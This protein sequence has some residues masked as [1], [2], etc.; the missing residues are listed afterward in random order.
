MRALLIGLIILLLVPCRVLAQPPAAPAA[1]A[2]TPAQARTALDVLND[3]RKRAEV[4]ATL[5]AIAKALPAPAEPATP[6]SPAPSPAK[7]AATTAKPVGLP[8]APNSLGAQVLVG[9]EDFLNRVSADASNGLRAMQSLPLL[10]GWIV[11]MA[12]DPWARGLLVGV[13]W[14]VAVALLCGLAV[15]FA[16]RRLIRRPVVA[17]EALA[18]S[19]RPPRT[20]HDAAT[21][22]PPEE[23]PEEPEDAAA[24]EPDDAGGEAPREPASAAAHAVERAEA[25]DIEPPLRRR[26]RPPASVFL[27]RVPLV[28]ARLVL[29]LIPVFGFAV[30]GHLV[31]ASD[32]GGQTSNRLVM[33]AVVDAYAVCAAIL[34]IA[35]MLLSPGTSRLRLFH[36]PDT[37]AAYLMRWTHRL[38]VIAVFG[39]AIAEVG[40]LLGLSDVAHDGL[41]KATGF[42]LHACLAAIVLQKRRAVRRWLRAPPGATGTIAWL[43]DAFASVWHWIALFFI[44]SIW[45]VWAVEIPHGF[46]RLLHF[47][48]VTAL[49]LIGAR[50]LLIVLTGSLDRLMNVPP[51]TAAR[52][53]G[54]EVRLRLY[55]PVLS[56]LLR[57]VVYVLCVL[58]ILQLYGFGAFTWFGESELGHR[59]VSAL[60]TFIVTLLL[61]LAAWEAANAAIQQHLAKL[62]KD[63][64]VARSARLRTLLPLMR[65]ALMI[66]ILVVAGMMVL[67]EVGINIAPLLAG[68]GIVGVAIGFGSQKL[69][70]DLITGIF[71]LLENA[72]QV[73]D[74]VTV[75]GLSGS[76][77]NLSVRTIRLRAGD[78]SV[79]IIPFSSVTTV[80][81]VNR[82]LGNASVN[83]TVEFDEDTDRVA[84]TL[85][86]IVAGMRAE[87]DFASKMLSDLQLWGVDK[88]DGAEAT[89]VGQVV[90]TDSGRWSVQREFNRRMKKRFQELGIRLYNP[91]RTVAVTLPPIR[92]SAEHQAGGRQAEPPPGTAEDEQA[93]EQSR[94]A[95]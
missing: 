46:P 92:P 84:A 30:A 57:A 12:T 82:G 91:M 73:G 20:K 38:V 88:V 83:V 35:R 36:L 45:L 61:A 28:L 64:Q 33:L 70:Q 17:L 14:R 24:D 77:E 9:A 62:A 68:A 90:C 51:E 56:A 78:G 50:L 93:H 41:Q 48:V 32:I 34:G 18:P 75:S 74:F 60:G 87:P 94:A 52:Y 54:L 80:T 42:V 58:A 26:R 55:H 44:V 10:W 1:P 65:S 79:H 7:P 15:E 53:P 63:Q 8:L 13:A 76:V 59:V 21:G 29:D 86:E 31:A 71:L 22:E 40:L 85:A 49:L 66:T 43:R 4:T 25:G 16:L 72:M 95:D 81:N 69:V 23:A 6:H 3:P 19:V 47:C 67:S 37:L 27:R 5:E 2:L 89:I 11:V 39:Y